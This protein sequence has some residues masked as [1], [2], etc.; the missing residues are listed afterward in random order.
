MIT[1]L[2][3]VVVIALLFPLISRWFQGFMLRRAEDMLRRAAGIPPADRK[4]RKAG[5]KRTE[6]TTYGRR[7]SQADSYGKGPIIPQEY[8]EDVEFVETK[9]YT[10]ERPVESET[11]FRQEKQ[12]TDVEWEEIK[13]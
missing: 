4:S 7:E 1:V 10:S 2:L 13:K 9:E 3:I 6:K 12:V 11:H 8:A 5:R